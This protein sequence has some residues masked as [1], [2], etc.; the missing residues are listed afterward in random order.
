MKNI[1]TRFSW[2]C[3][4]NIASSGFTDSFAKTSGWSLVGLLRDLDYDE[5]KSARNKHGVV[6]AKRLEGTYL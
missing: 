4:F 6:A 1:W 5:T 2:L 3:F